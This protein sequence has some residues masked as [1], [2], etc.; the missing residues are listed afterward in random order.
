MHKIPILDIVYDTTVDG[1]GFRTSIYAAGCTHCCAECHNP[2]SWN[3][4]NG[5]EYTIGTLFD[6]IKEGEFSD[7]TFTGGDPLMH[8]EAF[9][10][11]AKR[12]KTETNKTIWCYTGY[13]YENIPK[14]DRLSQ[15]LPFIDVLVDGRFIEELKDESLQFR[16]SSN[17]R[18]IDVQESLRK[19]KVIHWRNIPL[20][21]TPFFNPSQ[22]SF[23]R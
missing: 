5:K 23:V 10:E 13:V 16:G 12:I 9:T 8:V 18:I 7:V 19:K 17:Q 15:L 21:H 4:N 1:P 20:L 14:S 6:I 2:Q 11:L 3:V 22:A